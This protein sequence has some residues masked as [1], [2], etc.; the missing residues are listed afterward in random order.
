MIY[1]QNGNTCWTSKTSDSLWTSKTSDSMW[2]PLSAFPVSRWFSHGAHFVI[3]K[4]SSLWK[5]SLQS[6]D[7]I[8]RIWYNL[9]LKPWTTSKQ[10]WTEGCPVR[11]ENDLGH[12]HEFTVLSQCTRAHS[13]VTAHPSQYQQLISLGYESE[14]HSVMSDSLRL[15]GLYCPWNSSGQN[16]GVGSVS[17]LQGIFPTQGLNPS[18]LHCRQI[19][20]QLS[21]CIISWIRLEID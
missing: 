3:K 15:H 7:V 18:P 6:Y 10:C 11:M 20:Y 14:S 19:L 4:L 17:L 21:H 16:I 12:P 1:Q 2:T 13:L 8:R 5:R 9:M